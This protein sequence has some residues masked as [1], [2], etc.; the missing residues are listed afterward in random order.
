MRFGHLPEFPVVV[1]PAPAGFLDA[2]NAAEHM[3]QF[4][5][6]GVQ[7]FLNWR[8]Q[9]LGG[10][11]QLV[12][13]IILALPDPGN[14]TIPV[15][16]GLALHCNDGCGQFTAEKISVDS[17]VFFS[18]RPTARDIL[19]VSFMARSSHNKKWW[20]HSS[21]AGLLANSARIC[22]VPNYIKKLLF[23]PKVGKRELLLLHNVK[24]VVDFQCYIHI[25]ISIKR[26]C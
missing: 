9:N 6:D 1:G 25:L 17:M 15:C 8:V 4:V 11:I 18:K 5:D 2:M 14:T 26:I 23:F 24:P 12:G 19:L 20:K 16:A 7:D 3:A 21:R 22:D 10:D 13:I